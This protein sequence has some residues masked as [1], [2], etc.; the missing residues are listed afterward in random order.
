MLI[1][2]GAH[3]D[4]EALLEGIEEKRFSATL[5]LDS[6]RL[7]PGR[8]RCFWQHFGS[9]VT[10]RV[11]FRVSRRGDAWT[12]P[13]R[14]S[15]SWREGRSFPRDSTVSEFSCTYTQTPASERRVPVYFLISPSPFQNNLQTNSNKAS[16]VVAL[17]TIHN[18]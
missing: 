3:R 12:W 7:R 17:T 15:P 14:T 13:T 5:T 11:A 2:N 1:L 8:Q 4:A 9:S 6:V 18:H 16:P 10:L